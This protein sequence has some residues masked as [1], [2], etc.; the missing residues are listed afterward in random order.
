MTIAA[1][2]SIYA[3]QSSCYFHLRAAFDTYYSISKEA[4]NFIIVLTES[5]V[6]CST[7][8]ERENPYGT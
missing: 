2:F 5:L 7:E 1:K 8:G 6:D 3:F 4:N